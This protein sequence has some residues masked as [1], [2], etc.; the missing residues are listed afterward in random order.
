MTANDKG[1]ELDSDSETGRFIGSEVPKLYILELLPRLLLK[2]C[3]SNGVYMS[4]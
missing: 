1:W 4:S 2:S 3:P